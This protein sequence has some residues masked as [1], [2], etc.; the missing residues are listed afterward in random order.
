MSNPSSKTSASFKVDCL[1]AVAEVGAV[2]KSGGKLS[3]ILGSLRFVVAVV[4]GD[5]AIFV[6]VVVVVGELTCCAG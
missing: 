6:V 4:V 2:L 1:V 5:V 3:S